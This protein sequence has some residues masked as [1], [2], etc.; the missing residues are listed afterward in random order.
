MNL[1]L[2]P[3][4]DTAPI[5]GPEW[6]FQVLLVFT[7]FLHL[8][9][10]N[11]TLG[12]TL[13]AA[14]AHMTSGGRLDDPRTVLARR[15]VGI[16]TY[17]ISLTIT[18]GVAPLLFIQVLYQQYFYTATILIGTVWMTL[19]VLLM[20]GY[21]AVYVY[22]FGPSTEGRER[23][24][25]WI[26]FSAL[27]FFA[28]AMIH[29]AVNL[30]HS[31]PDTWRGLATSP[32]SVMGD[33]TY[34]A[35]LLHFVFAAVGFSALVCVWWAGRQAGR[36]IEPE[37]NDRIATY[38]WR[39]VL[40]STVLQVVDGFVL[41]FLLPSQVLTGLM[42]SGLLARTT[43]IVGVLVALGVLI[44]VTRVQKPTTS[45]GL[46]GGVLG[47]MVVTIAVMAILRHSVRALYLEPFTA[48]FELTAAPQWGNFALFAGLLVA[49]LASIAYFVRQVLSSP[50][51]GAD[52]A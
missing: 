14:V 5:P 13:L 7:F 15:L 49:G 17:A 20:A 43:L 28:I 1:D 3:A 34:V 42:Q 9:F 22:K 4:L 10:M 51:S 27:M 19:L 44:M 12:G 37:L 21:Y 31:Q 24:G 36:G 11:L 26:G 50:A 41:L 47:A 18:T 38:A 48:S 29:V 52:A 39:W 33:P 16:N 40:G 6:L 23:R 30:I 35:R 8:L 46:V 45:P 2:I 32:W 25:K